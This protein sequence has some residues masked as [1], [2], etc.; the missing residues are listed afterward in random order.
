MSANPSAAWTL[1]SICG[2]NGVHRVASARQRGARLAGNL[3]PASSKTIHEKLSDRRSKRSSCLHFTCT[4]LALIRKSLIDSGA[5]EG[6]RTLVIITKAD[7]CRNPQVAW[8]NSNIKRPSF[9]W[10]VRERLWPILSCSMPDFSS[11]FVRERHLE[12]SGV[13]L[14][15]CKSRRRPA[16][17]GTQPR[18][19]LSRRTRPRSWW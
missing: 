6:N 2:A 12:K 7:Y 16:R 9:T 3:E 4:L 17:G 14:A 10:H 1:Q 19:I 8:G 5:G 15:T 18:P 13:R 11:E